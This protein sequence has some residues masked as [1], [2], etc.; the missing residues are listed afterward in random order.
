MIVFVFAAMEV[1]LLLCVLPS[2][3][4]LSVIREVFDVRGPAE[5]VKVLRH[6]ALMR[7]HSVSSYR[8]QQHLVSILHSHV[9]RPAAHMIY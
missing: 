5:L 1:Y 6:S 3:V 2:S 7:Q 8:P 4:H 9:T